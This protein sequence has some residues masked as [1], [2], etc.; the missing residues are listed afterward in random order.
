[1]NRKILL[2]F[3]LEE[4]DLP[5]EYNILITK[6]KQLKVTNEG[7][8]ALLTILEKYSIIATFFTTA[9]YAENNPKIIK[10]IIKSGHE[11][12]SHLYY[13]SNYNPTH[14]LTSKQ[15]LEKISGTKI[16]GIRSPRLRPLSIEAIKDA[17]YIYNSSL[18]P[19]FIPGRYNNFNKPRRLFKNNNI[20]IMPFS[21][22]TIFRF[23]LFWLSFKNIPL[24]VY[25]FLCKKA[26][27]K[28]GEL[29]LYF[30]PWEFADLSNFDIPIYI[31]K[32]SGKKMVNKFEL[33]I[34][35][36]KDIGDFTTIYQFINESIK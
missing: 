28:D 22:S 1:M 9:Y 7:L 6:E 15:K 8:N 2:T 29:H 12:G 26:I 35:I 11:L 32:I 24:K 25:L 14:I 5:I 23:P 3:D 33:F 13:H 16:Y 17:G 27:K 18:N 10:N 34:Q 4:F 36:I 19:T 20:F 30:H 21:V 31:K